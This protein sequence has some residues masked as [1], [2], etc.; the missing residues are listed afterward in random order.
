MWPETMTDAREL[1]RCPELSAKH[2]ISTWWDS[3]QCC[4]RLKIARTVRRLAF[5]PRSP[6]L[7][8]RRVEKLLPF[9]GSGT[10]AVAAKQLGRHFI[11]IDI[12]P[13]YCEIAERRLSQEVLKL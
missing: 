1:L 10:T 13:K 7:R 9:L 6:F 8:V 11:G 4:E 3:D 5:C 12:N 2:L